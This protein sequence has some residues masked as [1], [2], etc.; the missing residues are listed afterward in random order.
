MGLH[1]VYSLTECGW[2]AHEIDAGKEIRIVAVFQDCDGVLNTLHILPVF[3]RDCPIFRG[4]PL[5]IGS[6][7]KTTSHGNKGQ[8]ECAT[9]IETDDDPIPLK[10]TELVVSTSS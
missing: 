7:E 9:N 10:P 4:V 5:M 8:G 6:P 3:A 2:R 1:S